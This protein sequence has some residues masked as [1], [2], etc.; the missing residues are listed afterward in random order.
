MVVALVFFLCSQQYCYYQLYLR[1][2][3]V[4]S[5]GYSANANR[6]IEANSDV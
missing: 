3:L 5:V 1:R 2:T 6:L 4:L